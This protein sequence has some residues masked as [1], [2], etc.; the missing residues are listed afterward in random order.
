MLATEVV[1]LHLDDLVQV[2]DARSHLSE[3]TIQASEFVV[4]ISCLARELV[5]ALRSTSDLT[6]RSGSV[7]LESLNFTLNSGESG[8]VLINLNLLAVGFLSQLVSLHALVTKQVLGLGQVV[9]DSLVGTIFLID[10]AS[11][12]IELLLTVAD[13]VALLVDVKASFTLVSGFVVGQHAVAVLRVEDVVLGRT[14]VSVVI[15]AE[16]AELVAQLADLAI[17]VVVAGTGHANDRWGA[18]CAYDRGTVSNW[19][20]SSDRRVVSDR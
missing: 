8:T 11:E 5:T 10:Q 13:L 2:F 14:H 9:T 16:L 12:V 4:L 1:R 20:A 6:T 17:A 3:F 19:G 15:G 7:V 18:R